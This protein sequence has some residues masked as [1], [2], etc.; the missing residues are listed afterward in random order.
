MKTT[1]SDGLIDAAVEFWAKTLDPDPEVAAT[2]QDDA[3]ILR[4]NLDKPAFTGMFER[5]R[6]LCKP[7]PE[8]I[9]IFRYELRRLLREPERVYG[10]ISTSHIELRTDYDPQGLLFLAA[11]TAGIKGKAFPFK[12]WLTLSEGRATS[13]G[14]I[15]YEDK[16][17]TDEETGTSQASAIAGST[18]QGAQS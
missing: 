10:V 11:E 8:Q 6:Q 18:G 16:D 12:T 5:V 2:P 1:F 15:I 4:L 3:A 13:G 14:K 9:L 7:T 17:N